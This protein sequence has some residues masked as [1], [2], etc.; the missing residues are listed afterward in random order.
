MSQDLDQHF[1]SMLERIQSDDFQ[2]GEGLSN[3]VEYYI[4]PYEAKDAPH[5][6]DK[7]DD[8]KVSPIAN[9][10]NLKVFD[11]YGIMIDSIEKIR[12][13]ADE[14]PFLM[15]EKMEKQ[16]G[17]Q[18]VAQQINNL[19]RMDENN[20]A[21]V[22]YVDEHTDKQQRC[23]IFI[24]GVGRVYPLIRAHKVLNTMHQVLDH[25]PVVMFYPGKYN[26]LSLQIF[27]ETKDQNYYRAFPI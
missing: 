21:V 3:E 23:V 8:L 20:N 1:Q 25:N 26:E 9:K 16:G 2:E 17:I 14:D 10:I 15:L 27:G 18:L 11:L 24:T 6:R 5:L 22:Q 19:M 7:I 13:I 12:E 4:F